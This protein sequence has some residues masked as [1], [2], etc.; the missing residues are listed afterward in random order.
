MQHQTHLGQAMEQC[1]TNC[2]EC[3]HICLETTTHCL[4]MGG[5]HAGVDHIGLM[6][7]CAQSCQTSADFMLR[8]SPYHSRT[9][10][11]CAEVCERCAED[12]L[13]IAAGNDA[14]MEAC[15]QICRR[16]AESCRKMAQTRVA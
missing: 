13:Q 5:K 7:D 11:V 16:C 1:I 12:C 8:G 2:Q 14:Q 15:A 3:H 10:G 6:Q 4:Q 9:C